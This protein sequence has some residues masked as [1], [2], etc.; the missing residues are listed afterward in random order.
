[1]F[2]VTGGCAK[3]VF[4]TFKALADVVDVRKDK[5]CSFV[6]DGFAD[7]GA[8]SG[9]VKPL[10]C[11]MI[12]SLR[13]ASARRYLPRRCDSMILRRSRWTDS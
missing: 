5:S 10:S 11:A 9:V 13:D 6:R 7:S 3:P 2:A 8:S 4:V 12:A 1:M